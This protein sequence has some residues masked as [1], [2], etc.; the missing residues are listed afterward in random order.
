M[1]TLKITAKKVRKCSQTIFKITL[2]LSKIEIEGETPPNFIQII[3]IIN[4]NI[5][6]DSDKSFKFDWLYDLLATRTFEESGDYIVT[7]F[8]IEPLE[9]WDF[10]IN[11]LG[12]E[13]DIEGVFDPDDDKLLALISFIPFQNY[14]Y[15]KVFLFFCHQ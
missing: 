14:T 9:Y 8:P 7:E 6:G 5:V 12:E 15:P 2:N 1:Q 3:D 4:G 13:V 11:E 10:R